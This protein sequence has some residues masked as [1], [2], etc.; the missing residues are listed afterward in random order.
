[1]YLSIS[2]RQIALHKLRQRLNAPE[3]LHDVVLV[4]AALLELEQQ[5]AHLGDEVHLNGLARRLTQVV[6]H[7]LVVP[8]A[9]EPEQL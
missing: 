9:E 2:L 3:G 6:L 5:T 7:H 4:D 1:M 8:F